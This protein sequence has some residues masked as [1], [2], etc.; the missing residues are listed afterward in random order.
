MDGVEWK[1]SLHRIKKCAAEF[2]SMEGDLVD[3]DDDDDDEGS[4]ELIGRDIRLKSM[5]LYCDLHRV[6]SGYSDDHKKAII[7]LGNSPRPL[8]GKNR[9]KLHLARIPV[10]NSGASCQEDFGLVVWKPN[11]NACLRVRHPVPMKIAGTG[12]VV[13]SRQFFLTGAWDH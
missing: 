5:F 10:H 12:S 7:D 6:I 9:F 4:W 3:S 1:G 2:L 11:S 8:N 13:C